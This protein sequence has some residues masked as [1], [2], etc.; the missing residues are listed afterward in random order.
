MVEKNKKAQAKNKKLQRVKSAKKSV[1]RIGFEP[2]SSSE[3]R[4]QT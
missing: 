4:T 3:T 2:M 1:A